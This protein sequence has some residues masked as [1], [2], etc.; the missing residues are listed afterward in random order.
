MFFC[1]ILIKASTHQPFLSLTF[2]ECLE[3]VCVCVSVYDV[4]SS[5][6][7]MYCVK[8]LSFTVF[9][10]IKKYSRSFAKATDFISLT[11]F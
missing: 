11:L 10:F 2:F 6:P 8:I 3:C 5:V 1:S 7:K 4:T 9:F